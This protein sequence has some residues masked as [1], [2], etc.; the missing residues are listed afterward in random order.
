MI[1]W[2]VLLCVL[3]AGP[4]C[5]ERVVLGLSQDEVAITA[6]FDGSDV[7]IFG[8]VQ[9][10]TAAPEGAPLGVIITLGGPER[11]ATIWKKVRRLGIW[12]NGP[13]LKL[14]NAPTFYAVAT[15]DPLDD[16]L[17]RR[18]DLRHRI[19]TLRALHYL[20]DGGPT[21]TAFVESMI[22]IRSSEGRFQ[23]LEGQVSVEEETLFHTRITLPS[24]LTEGD[25]AARIFLTRGGEVVD[26][27]ETVIPVIKVGLERWLYSLAHEQ[28]LI[29]GLL[30]LAIAIAA[31]WLA[32]AVFRFIKT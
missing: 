10:D 6:T 1:R 12:A 22:R 23:Q 2:V 7:L 32:S 15:S 27:Y 31:G 29:Y 24:N 25:Y 9:R 13:S 16:I 8:A 5:A 17:L 21:H 14:L 28:S 26:S 19:S 30:S 20:G 3:V 11:T 18:E 4:A